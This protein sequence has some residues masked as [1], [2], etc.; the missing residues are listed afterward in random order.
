M[1]LPTEFSARVARNTQLILQEETLI[2][3][4][5]DPFGGNT[6][7]HNTTR[8]TPCNQVSWTSVLLTSSFASGNAGSYM[9]ESLTHELAAAAQAVIDEVE[10]R[11]GMA[12][13]VADGTA[14]LRIEEA[15]TRKQARIDSLEVRC[16]AEPCAANPYAVMATHPSPIPLLT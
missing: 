3:K 2:T 11:G 1:G 9:M 8:I 15:A 10:A 5:A 13:C 7:H 14:K 16:G 6:T 4:V 12:A